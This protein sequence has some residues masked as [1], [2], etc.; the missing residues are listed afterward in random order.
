MVSKTSQ[1]VR[2]TSGIKNA[3]GDPPRAWD[4]SRYIDVPWLGAVPARSL[5]CTPNL[6]SLGGSRRVGNRRVMPLKSLRRWRRYHRCLCRDM[7]IIRYHRRHRSRR[8]SAIRSGSNTLVDPFSRSRSCF[9]VGLG[10][11]RYSFPSKHPILILNA[12]HDLRVK[13]DHIATEQPLSV[14]QTTCRV[15]FVQELVP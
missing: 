11:T 1:R 15:H 3:V 12:F 7:T 4:L 2:N 10:H 5:H 8:T 6:P 14:R 9:F 13:L